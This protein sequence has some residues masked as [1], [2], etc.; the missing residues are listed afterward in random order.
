MTAP[1][2]RPTRRTVR[3]NDRMVGWCDII[4]VPGDDA[5]GPTCT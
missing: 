2:A 5:A 1:T 3:D 4:P